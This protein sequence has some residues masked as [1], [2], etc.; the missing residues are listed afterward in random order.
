VRESTSGVIESARSRSRMRYSSKNTI[1]RSLAK[2]ANLS[3]VQ[4]QKR[5][6]PIF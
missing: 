4:G 3:E 5:S 1:C 2:E 6:A